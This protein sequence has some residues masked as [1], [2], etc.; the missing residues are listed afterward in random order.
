MVRATFDHFR[1]KHHFFET[2]SVIGQKLGLRIKPKDHASL[3]LSESQISSQTQVYNRPCGSM[4]S[5]FRHLGSQKTTQIINCLYLR[6]RVN[7]QTRKI[8]IS[9]HF[10]DNLLQFDLTPI[11][12]F[13]HSYVLK[14]YVT[15]LSID[16]CVATFTFFNTILVIGD[17]EIVYNA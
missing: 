9:G 11:F 13:M 1:S 14:H 3:S 5:W 16:N 4:K 2:D 8:W 15:Q 7:L 10:F 6:N 17:F 12:S